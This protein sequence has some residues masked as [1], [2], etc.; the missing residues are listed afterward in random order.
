M[1]KVRQIFL[2]SLVFAGLAHAEEP[3][4]P[5]KFKASEIYDAKASGAIVG[6]WVKGVRKPAQAG[7][8]YSESNLS[9]SFKKIRA[10]LLSATTA[11]DLSARLEMLEVVAHEDRPEVSG[12][13][14]P[15]KVEP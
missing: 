11:D 2:T 10:S 14:E 15:G 7:M 4:A 1:M 6:Q 8:Q 9:E 3:M 5:P 12:G 13:D